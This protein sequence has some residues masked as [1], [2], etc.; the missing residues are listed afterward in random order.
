MA[1]WA[2]DKYYYPLITKPLNRFRAKLELP[3]VRRIFRD[4][5]HQGDCVL[6]MFPDWFADRP[7]DWPSN[8]EL[9]GFPLY[10]HALRSP[11]SPDVAEFIQAGAPPVVF[12]AGTAN[13]NA[14][15]FFRISIEGCRKAGKRAILLSHFDSQLPER[16]PDGMIHARHAPFGALLPQV[17][18]FVHHG[19]IGTTSQA[20]KAGV[21]QLIRPTA[22]DQFDNAARAVRL[23]VASKLLP[24]RYSAEAVAAALARMTS[25]QAMLA[26]CRQLA[27]RLVQGNATQATCDTIIARCSCRRPSG[28][29]SAARLGKR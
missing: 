18:A 26:R 14:R 28:N 27:A 25:D 10:D 20:L 13:A 3:P 24:K 4:W 1:W 5:I 11:L 17:A 16:L 9:P 22:Y 6:G 15:D 8:V 12:T 21:P 2:A 23:G 29:L 19:G 7:G